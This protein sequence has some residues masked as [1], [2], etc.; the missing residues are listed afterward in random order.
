MLRRRLGPLQQGCQIS[1]RKARFRFRDLLGCSLSDDLAA[2]RAAFRTEVDDPIRRFDH[3][4]IMLDDH[5][6]VALISQ[7]VDHFEQKRDVVEVQTGRRF[8]E[9]IK[10]PTGVALAQFQRKL[11]ALCLAT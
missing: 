9:D 5:D 3:V 4:E 6:R 11:D 8:I 1:A 7:T 2:T 10:S